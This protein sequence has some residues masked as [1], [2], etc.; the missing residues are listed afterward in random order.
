MNKENRR[1]EIVPMRDFNEYYDY[2]YDTTLRDYL[3]KGRHV[4]KLV[5]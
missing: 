3:F 1:K 4:R 2:Y 5:T